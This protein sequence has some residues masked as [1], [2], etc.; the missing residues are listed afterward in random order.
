L[1][2]GLHC[3]PP[4]FFCKQ[5]ARSTEKKDDHPG[6]LSACMILATGKERRNQMLPE[7]YLIFIMNMLPY[8]KIALIIIQLLKR[9]ATRTDNELDDMLVN[10]IENILKNALNLN[11]EQNDN[12]SLPDIH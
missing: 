12:R 1:G 3:T 8:D 9:I 5:D 7:N 11:D 4:T 6:R 2:E 10:I